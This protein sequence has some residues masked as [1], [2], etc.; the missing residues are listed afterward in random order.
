MSNIRFRPFRGKEDKILALDKRD[1]QIYFA[2]D[3]GKMYLDIDNENRI[4]LGGNGASIFYAEA[5]EGDILQDAERDFYTIDNDLL[6]DKKST[7]K[8]ND[9]IINKDGTFYRIDEVEVN[10]QK[11]LYTCTKI[12]VSGNGT[13]SGTSSNYA[14]GLLT[15]SLVG[16]PS[17]LN[18]DDCI[19]NISL[20]S[21]TEDG[22]PVEERMN[23]EVLY[24]VVGETTPYATD[25]ISDVSH[26]V[27][28]FRYNASKKLRY[29][30]S[31]KVLFKVRPSSE[32]NI[33]KLS[34]ESAHTIS[35]YNLNIK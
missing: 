19:F 14:R 1:G 21:A 34:G 18:G 22:I 29:S 27:T 7:P 17:I 15:A 13:G 12:A 32:T 5:A 8:V 16:E 33:F 6:T 26:G 10:N 2:T 9:L 11:I 20:L 30:T 4:P 23:I 35:T 24:T 25:L 3:S 31:T 28:G